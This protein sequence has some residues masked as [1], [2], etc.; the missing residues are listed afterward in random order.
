MQ[1]AP[2]GKDSLMLDAVVTPKVALARLLV[3][4]AQGVLLYLLYFAARAQQWPATEAYLFP[5]LLLLGVLLPVLLISSLGHLAPR[6][7]AVWMAVAALVM[8]LLAVYDVWRLGGIPTGWPKP[9]RLPTL[10]TPS[11]LLLV[12]SIGGFFIAHAL[13]LAG[14]SERRRIAH[15]PSY[16]EMAW[17]LAIQL[18]FS[19]FFINMLWMVLWLG[20]ALFMLV[21]LNFLKEVLAESWFFIPVTCFAFSC[22]MHL[23]DVRPAIVRGIRTLLLVLLSWILPVTVLIVGGFLFSLPFTGLSAL[24]ETRH[25]TSVL[26]GTAAALVILIN[27]AYQNGEVSAGVA[28][29]IAVSARLAA[30]LLLPIWAIAVYALSL[31]VG[32]YGWT[33]DR[34]TAAACL[35]VAAFYAFG[36][37]WA[38]REGGRERAHWMRGV[39]KVN[40]AT[41]F[42]VLAVLL[43][44]FSPLGDSAR[45]S[46]NN[47]MARLAAGSIKAE[48][49]D[50]KY[51]RFDGAR[52]GRQALEQLRDS[53][54]GAEAALIRAKAKAVLK[55]ENRWEEENK[56]PAPQPQDI[57]ANLTV[58]PAKARLP[59]SFLRKDWQKHTSDWEVS[60]C[61]KS[62]DTH[63]DAYVI[64][65]DGDGKPEVL[66]MTQEHAWSPLMGENAQGDWVTVGKL[67]FNSS[68]C[69]SLRKK[70]SAG[71]FKLVAR[72]IKDLQLD[73]VRMAIQPGGDEE[74]WRCPDPK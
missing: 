65:F 67:P 5:T 55:A 22:A 6:R 21:K 38:A 10:P 73:G 56:E 25:A 7:A 42:V 18:Q 16:F 72:P 50:F 40:V 74:G 12:A 46:V 26:L 8:V 58:W 36:Y 61:L 51:L 57:A 9:E 31:R 52:Y 49:F 24:W 30:L 44:L 29:V 3:G 27:A 11:P 47:Q 15:Y 41:A 33:A 32:D 53:T 39:A 69:A 71:D 43:A 19:L 54:Q 63:C 28:R 66:L 13:V 64:D 60:P 2:P 45:L 62:K 4:L 1:Q 23:T 70:L 48:Q 20:S 17:K 14:A 37:G 35:L 34:I 59:D 68:K